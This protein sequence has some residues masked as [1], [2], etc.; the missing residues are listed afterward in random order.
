M[1]AMHTYVHK[2][3]LFTY[4]CNARGFVLINKLFISLFYNSCHNK[5]NILYYIISY[6]MLHPIIYNTRFFSYI[7]KY[8][9]FIF[10]FPPFSPFVRQG[11]TIEIVKKSF[12][13]DFYGND[14][15]LSIGHAHFLVYGI[16][17]VSMSGLV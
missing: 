15:D 13:F 6:S 17:V 1:S 2:L 12:F 16:L 7:Y 11:L 4:Y 8:S 10:D 5:T 9:M 14:I 3:P